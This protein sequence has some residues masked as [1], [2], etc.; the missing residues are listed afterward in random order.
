MNNTSK[1]SPRKRG[2]VF[3]LSSPPLPTRRS[4]VATHKQLV[5]IAHT[6]LQE[7]GTVTDVADLVDMVKTGCAKWGL[8]WGD[9]REITKAI[10]SAVF[11]R[12]FCR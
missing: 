4:E 7:H 10:E 5:K 12:R 6:V 9:P 2:R 8:T 3:R 11:Q 1:S